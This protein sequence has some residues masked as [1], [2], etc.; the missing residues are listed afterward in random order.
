MELSL[1]KKISSKERVRE[2]ALF[3]L[4]KPKSQKRAMLLSEGWRRTGAVRT[5]KN[6]LTSVQYRGLQ[7]L[8]QGEFNK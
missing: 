4:K 7:C 6:L 2:E 5:G 3:K 1:T 8:G